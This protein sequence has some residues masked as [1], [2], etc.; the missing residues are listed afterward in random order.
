LVADDKIVY[1]MSTN[2]ANVI[3]F[4][5]DT[6]FGYFV[7]IDFEG[8]PFLKVTFQYFITR[9][10]EAGVLAHYTDQWNHVKK[11]EED[12]EAQVLTTEKLLVGFEIYLGCLVFSA[13]VLLMEFVLEKFRECTKMLKAVRRIK[14][15]RNERRF[16]F[17]N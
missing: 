3:R 10:K 15:N 12:S 6:Y 14:K 7:G 17:I 11:Y 8:S 2:G 4:F 16:S 5:E 9:M 13:F 1:E